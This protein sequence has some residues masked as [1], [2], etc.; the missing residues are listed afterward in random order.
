MTKRQQ[1]TAVEELLKDY[2][3]YPTG[4][5]AI[6][7]RVDAKELEPVKSSG[8]NGKH[9]ALHNRYRIIKPKEDTSQLEGELAYKIL[10]PLSPAYYQKHLSQYQTDR[11]GILAL[12]DYLASHNSADAFAM[13]VSENERS[14]EIWGQEKYLKKE[15]RRVLKNL[16]LD[17]SFLNVYETMEPLSLYSISRKHP[18]N[19]LILENRDP[20]F[21]IR[22]LLIEAADHGKDEAEILGI[23]IST[24]AYGSGKRIF[25]AF[26]EFLE[27]GDPALNHPDNT[28]YYWG[29]LD[30]EGIAMYTGLA[31]RFPQANIKLFIPAYE[32]MMQKGNQVLHLPMTKEGQKQEEDTLFWKQL[33]SW[34]QKEGQKLLENRQYIPQ[35]ILTIKDYMQNLHEEKRTEGREIS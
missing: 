12:A 8:L 13:P 1:G 26:R 35:E 15:G 33:P 29:D 34:L 21:S 31:K 19:L 18:Q 6:L 30:Y 14:F 7:Q 2:P 17:L 24:I 4:A 3:D 20:L 27:F 23:P 16:G 22:R 28:I 9:P 11:P 10:P 5:D 25:S 32:A